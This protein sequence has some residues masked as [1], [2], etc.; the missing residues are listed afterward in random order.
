MQAKV[1]HAHRASGSGIAA[2]VSVVLLLIGAS[3]TFSSLNTALDIVFKVESPKGISGLALL[4]R[5]RLVSFGLVMGFGFLLVVSLV[6][7]RPC[8]VRHHYIDSRRGRCP[9]HFRTGGHDGRLRCPH[10]MATR[11]SCSLQKRPRRRCGRGGAVCHGTTSL[12]PLSNTR[13]DHG[14]LRSGRVA[15]RRHD[16]AV[17][18][19]RRVSHWR[20]SDCDT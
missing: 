12:R 3:A 14:F 1:E 8:R 2:A 10:Q 15:G 11:R 20:G 9:N 16:V 5:A 4:L 17:L 13:W 19:S 7:G 6:L 18:L